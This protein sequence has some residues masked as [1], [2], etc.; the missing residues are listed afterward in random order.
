M[1]TI[2]HPNVNGMLVYN[3]AGAGITGA[4]TLGQIPAGAIIHRASIVTVKA[5]G[6]GSSPLLVVGISGTTNKYVASVALTVTAGVQA[7]TVNSSNT[8]PTAAETILL[9]AS[10]TWPAGTTYNAY[11][12]VEFV[13]V[14]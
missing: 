11:V 8:I 13:Q 7:L 12:I 4:L 10:G 6:A 3:L 9:T 2:T 5:D 14:A 1:A